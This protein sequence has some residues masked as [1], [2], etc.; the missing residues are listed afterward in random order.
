[1]VVHLV[2]LIKVNLFLQPSFEYSVRVRGVNAY[3]PGPWSEVATFM[4]RPPGYPEL[5]CL[6]KIEPV[7]DVEGVRVCWEPVQGAEEY[8]LAVV[9]SSFRLLT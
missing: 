4:I 7:S 3:G 6:T 5:P 8:C 2:G 9:R 1:M